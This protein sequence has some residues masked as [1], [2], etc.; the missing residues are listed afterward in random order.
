MPMAEFGIFTMKDVDRLRILQDVID[1]KLRL[2]Q[3]ARQIG[4]TAIHF[5]RLLRRYREY[6]RLSQIDQGDIIDNKRL[7]QV[8]QV[9]K[10]VQEQRDNRRS[11]ALPSVDGPDRSRNRMKIQKKSQRS[12]N[13]DDMLD[14]MIK[15]QGSSES[16]FGKKV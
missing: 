15:L 1:R 3:A 2:G 12:L 6:D 5:S 10:L 8:L 4:V 13:E 14:A 7:S 11:K 16:I 9:A